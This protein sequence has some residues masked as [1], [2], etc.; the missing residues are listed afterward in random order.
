MSATLPQVFASQPLH[1]LCPVRGR[2]PVRRHPAVAAGVAAVVLLTAAGCSSDGDQTATPGRSAP[3]S[4]SASSGAPATPVAV[5]SPA[6]LADQLACTGL[7]P[8]TALAG[9]TVDQQGTCTFAGG[10][11]TL[12][13]F[14]TAEDL[15]SWS[16]SVRE[17]GVEAVLFG[18]T[19][20]ITFPTRDAGQAAQRRLGGRLV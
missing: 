2:G 18:G 20:A 5:R 12:F 9:P 6:E 8:A 4:P 15:N 17:P 7:A 16:Q 14:R 10:T 3:G 1:R 19:W 13:T 11:A